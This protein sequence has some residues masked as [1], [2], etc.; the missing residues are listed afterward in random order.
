[1]AL[2][3]DG[4]IEDHT[5]KHFRVNHSTVPDASDGVFLYGLQSEDEQAHLQT[6]LSETYSD[7]LT[8]VEDGPN[9]PQITLQCGT[10]RTAASS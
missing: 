10:L 9:G 1:M 8:G 2:N 3:L 7:D 5:I 4:K 6:G